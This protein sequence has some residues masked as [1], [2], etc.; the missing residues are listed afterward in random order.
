M[1]T[2]SSDN[3]GANH[4]RPHRGMVLFRGGGDPTS[5][6]TRVSEHADGV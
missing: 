2:F 6:G 1:V 3:G 4:F 5:C